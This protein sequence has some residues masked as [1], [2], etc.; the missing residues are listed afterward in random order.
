[1]DRSAR[2]P[3]MA[4]AL[5]TGA[6]GSGKTRLLAEARRR[7]AAT[8]VTIAGYE[9]AQAVPLTAAR[10]LLRALVKARR[11]GP[12]LGAA[13]F[14]GEG[15]GA[16]T[17][18]PLRLFEAAYRCLRELAP[19]TIVADDVQ[20][21][22]ST[23]A[24]LMSYLARA[25]AADR[26]G[27]AILAAA[28]PSATVGS[29]RDTLHGIL[30]DRLVELSL[31]PL[32]R[33]AGIALAHDLAPT[34][35][36]AEAS[37]IWEVA[38][39]SP[40]WIAA[41]TIDGG[42]VGTELERRF[43]QLGDEAA[44]VLSAIAVIGRPTDPSEL[45]AALGW[46]EARVAEAILELRTRG[47]AV[48]ASG[49][50]EAAHDLIRE[51]AAHGVPPDHARRIHR[52]HAANLEATAGDDVGRLRE[53]LDHALAGGANVVD[54]ALR[55]A[56]AP[57]RRLIGPAGVGDLVRVAEA[58]DG[59]DPRR[60]ELNLALAE[61]ATELGDR[62]LELE[63][64]ALVAEHADGSPRI[65][66]L[67]AAAKAA[68][69]LGRRDAA[70]ALVDQ[71]RTRH[72][73]D[74]LT[75]V[76]LDALESE[77]LRW[78][79]HRLPEARRLTDR[80]LAVVDTAIDEATRA[81]DPIPVSL[82]NAAV[83][84]LSA[85][86]DL[87]LQ[88]GDERRQT[89]FA[90]RLVALADGDLGRME[91]QL[92]V[93][94]AHRRSGRTGDAELIARRV[95]EQANRRL[96]P[97][98]MVAAG[99]H[100]ARALYSLGRLEEAEGAAAEAERWSARIG[101]TGRFLSEMRSLRP[102]IAV[103]RGDWRSGIGH[104]RQDIEREPDPHYRL[105][106]HQEIA[107]WLARL[108]PNEAGDEVQAELAAAHANLEAVGCPRC[109]RE[110]A[111]RGAEALARIGEVDAARQAIRSQA[112]GAARRSTESRLHLWR[113]IASIRAAS[114]RSPVS[115]AALERLRRHLIAA[116]MHREAM[117]SDL[118]RADLMASIDVDAAVEIYRSIAE[119]AAAGGVL[120]DLGIA[121]Q[122]LR[123]LGRRAAPPRPA[124]GPMGL[125]ARQLEVARLAAA[126]TSN[127]EIARTLFL[128][129]KTV[130][131]HVSA[132]LLKTGARNRTELAA[133][134]L[135]HGSPA[136]WK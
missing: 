68:Y 19:M 125:T 66:A 67:V 71:A 23:T 4:A 12:D 96:Y 130:E 80:A 64:W 13:A 136:R 116:G 62:R 16:A 105:G 126:G 29:L 10:E 112:T 3:S 26:T 25:A 83:E 109:G 95:L 101:D 119:R 24:A 9:P 88:D 129:R 46:P 90:E 127:P 79:D 77:I 113:A 87:A 30:G 27:L 41:L 128:S 53:A 8:V 92:L 70:A 91:A 2:G 86:Y 75:T 11:A 28:R 50:V 22:D 73:A 97:A 60:H 69:R 52:R 42:S 134:L 20:W 47:L 108:A 38:A 51:A 76:A 110:L 111:L 55:L 33:E 17:T 98:V 106:I 117:W 82:R 43:S 54:I 37:R 39:G 32:P 84:A 31:G 133:R 57:D 34:V 59:G 15:W 122:R 121:K 21:M 5:V 7:C 35:S 72:E 120:T 44:A 45:A 49:A 131:R 132:A 14:G 100:L 102:A 103:S 85:A 1:M 56:R 65:S 36:T 115:V 99:Q 63:R 94:L 118:D 107:V 40:F 48:E 18:A 6:P 93:A 114:A 123:A 58:T 135:E 104:L 81:G 78:L 89:H 74:L 124:A 61:L